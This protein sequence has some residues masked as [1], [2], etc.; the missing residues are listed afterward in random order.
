M[1][2]YN[3]R[4]KAH[5]HPKKRLTCAQIDMTTSGTSYC[6]IL[7]NVSTCQP[8]RVNFRG[9]GGL[10]GPEIDTSATSFCLSPQELPRH[11][12][13]KPAGTSNT[14]S[15]SAFVICRLSI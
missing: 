6:I 11:K 4:E 8:F 3:V 7:Y 13:E 5:L 10:G 15:Q 14:A 9:L 1:C 2:E 12:R